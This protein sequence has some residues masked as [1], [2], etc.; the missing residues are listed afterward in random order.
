MEDHR[1]F[2]FPLNEKTSFRINKKFREFTREKFKERKIITTKGRNFII[3]N[4]YS[5]IAKFKFEELCDKNLGAE[6]YINIAN[7]CTHIFIEE[8]P[9]FNDINS[10]QQ[11]R[12]ITL[13]DILYEKEISLTLSLQETKVLSRGDI[14]HPDGKPATTPAADHS[15]T[16]YEP[17]P[18]E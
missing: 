2:F 8:I 1:R 3:E 5:G 18:E 7:I 12:F 16:A 10:N 11:L 6:D 4:F 15:Y 9:V 13:I 14:E 17:N